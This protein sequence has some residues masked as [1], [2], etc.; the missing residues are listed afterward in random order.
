MT[1]I[2]PQHD[3]VHPHLLTVLV[4]F[5]D[6][7]VGVFIGHDEVEGFLRCLTAEAPSEASHEE[8]NHGNG[9]QGRSHGVEDFLRRFKSDGWQC[10]VCSRLTINS[11]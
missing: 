8:D 2:K 9:T 6:G 7:A 10:F 1:E 4:V 3:G 11:L 5:H